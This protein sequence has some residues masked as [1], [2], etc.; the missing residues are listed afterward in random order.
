MKRQGREVGIQSLILKEIP[1]QPALDS[2][3]GAGRRS[4]QSK[5]S[6]GGQTLTGGATPPPRTISRYRSGRGKKAGEGV[7]MSKV[8]SR[9]KIAGLLSV[10]VEEGDTDLIWFAIGELEKG[11]A[12]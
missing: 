2:A 3:P 10:A 4:K 5:A 9:K 11:E 1:D 6:A 12:K 7:E 8:M